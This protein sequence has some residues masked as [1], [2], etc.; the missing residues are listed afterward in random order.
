MGRIRDDLFGVFGRRIRTWPVLRRCIVIYRE[1][2]SGLDDIA[3][4]RIADAGKQPPAFGALAELFT[5]I[6]D[7]HEDDAT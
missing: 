1:P 2:D 4:V 7:E 6:P 5:D 3:V